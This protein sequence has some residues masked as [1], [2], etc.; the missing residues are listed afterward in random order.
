MC[1]TF[2]CVVWKFEVTFDLSTI[3]RPGT[4][5]PGSSCP[6]LEYPPGIMKM[7]P[8]FIFI[9]GED[10][11]VVVVVV[12]LAGVELVTPA[13]VGAT[14]MAVEAFLVL[15]GERSTAMTTVTST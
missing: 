7:V 2:F 3:I 11:L 9:D 8:E 10:E 13:S 6:L 4:V 12:L 14:A 15:I 1:I 5:L